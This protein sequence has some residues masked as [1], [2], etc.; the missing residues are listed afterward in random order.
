[1]AD[2]VEE[3]AK[4]EA[5]EWDYIV[6]EKEKPNGK[7]KVETVKE[8]GEEGVSLMKVLMV[9]LPVEPK[10]EARQQYWCR[11][12]LSLWEFLV[13]YRQRAL[14]RHLRFAQGQGIR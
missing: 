1:M 4:G 7:A 3:E 5:A 9:K 14:T 8:K 11:E 12:P 2:A 10:L 6:E 13:L